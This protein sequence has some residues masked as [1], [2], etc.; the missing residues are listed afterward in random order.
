MEICCSNKLDFLFKGG[1]LVRHATF[2]CRVIWN[3][4][5]NYFHSWIWVKQKKR[6]L[7]YHT[8]ERFCSL[9]AVQYMMHRVPLKSLERL[10]ATSIYWITHHTLWCVMSTNLR[11]QAH[12]EPP[13]PA[14]LHWIPPAVLVPFVSLI[15]WYLTHSRSSF[16]TLPWPG[17]KVQFPSMYC[18]IIFS[19][20][21]CGHTWRG[22][23]G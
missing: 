2:G 19:C 14:L 13:T 21:C 7:N 23:N 17:S 20:L 22:D 1:G 8:P 12:V 11:M 18:I 15:A 5:K 9:T 4:K 10:S 16:F 3:L 6:C